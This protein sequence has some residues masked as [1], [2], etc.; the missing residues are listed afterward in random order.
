MTPNY[1][2]VTSP[3]S[4][5]LTGTGQTRFIKTRSKFTFP[6]T[7]KAEARQ[8]WIHPA[9]CL[10][11]VV[12]LDSGHEG[13]DR[14]VGDGGFAC[15]GW[16]SLGG[17]RPRTWAV[18]KLGTF[19]ISLPPHPFTYS[20]TPKW[21]QRARDWC[22]VI[23]FSALSDLQGSQCRP[24]ITEQGGGLWLTGLGL[25]CPRGVGGGGGSGICEVRSDLYFYYNFLSG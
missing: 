18:I 2:L 23:F 24:R 6:S 11:Y 7:S 8:L 25:S 3:H 21:A 1:W 12:V 19:A 22:L 10:C 16:E 9:F 14:E 4:S 13:T 17:T 15:L 5:C 20:P